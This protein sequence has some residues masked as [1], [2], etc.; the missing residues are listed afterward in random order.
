ML[1]IGETINDL[2]ILE[3]L[4]RIYK[5]KSHYYLCR[6]ICGKIKKIRGDKI[7]E[8]ST[9]SCGCKTRFK[10]NCI[11]HR[12]T[13]GMSHTKEYAAWQGMK[14]RC[15]NPNDGEYGNYGGR[16]ISVCEE[17]VNSF[18]TFFKDVGPCPTKGHSLD[19]I[20]VNGNYCK[21]N[22]KWSNKYE[23]ARNRRNNRIIE[24]KGK[25]QTLIEWS[26][27]LNIPRLCITKRLKRGWTIEE[28]LETPYS[29]S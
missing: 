11:S 9:K 22:V 12:K 4:G 25:S 29:R 28:A 13:H 10:K 24:Y 18:E 20:R 7:K 27:E 3:H 26:I 1:K 16:G 21:D 23:Q 2:T 6:C 5:N 19:R 8:G 17:W 15:F 14:G